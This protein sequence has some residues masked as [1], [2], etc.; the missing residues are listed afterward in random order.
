[1]AQQSD[2]GGWVALNHLTVGDDSPAACIVEGERRLMTAVLVHALRS[3]R[4]DAE[5]PGRGAARRLHQDLDW[6]TSS[7]RTGVFCFERICESLSLDADAVRRRVLEQLGASTAR[8][9][10][11]ASAD[12]PARGDVDFQPALAVG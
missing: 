5:R 9:A 1:M 2:S 3:L 8:L 6:L 11:M 4:Q 7:E 12:R 10:P